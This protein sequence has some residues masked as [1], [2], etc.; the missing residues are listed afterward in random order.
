[1][2]CVNNLK[3]WSDL[4]LIKLAITTSPEAGP[5]LRITTHKYQEASF[6]QWG[7]YARGS[8]GSRRTPL[9]ISYTGTTQ[10]DYWIRLFPL[11]FDLF[12]LQMS[13]PIMKF[14]LNFFLLWR[15]EETNLCRMFT[16][17]K[18]LFN[19][20]DPESEHWLQPDST[21]KYIVWGSLHKNGR[22]SFKQLAISEAWKWVKGS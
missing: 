5:N 3:K 11:F 2:T 21:V 1:M 6:E 15:H 16:V 18:D 20:L 17:F 14:P 22:W 13:F 12:F 9:F 10:L 4:S 8:R 19:I 7:P